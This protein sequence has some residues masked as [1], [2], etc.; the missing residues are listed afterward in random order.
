[1]KTRIVKKKKRFYPQYRKYLWWFN[2]KNKS[3]E[4]IDLSTE[5]TAIKFLNLNK[6]L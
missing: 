3:G 2:F 1:M 6:G 5:H 4:S